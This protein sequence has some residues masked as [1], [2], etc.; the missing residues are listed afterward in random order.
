MESRIFQQSPD[1]QVSAPP[2]GHLPAG[3]KPSPGGR[4]RATGR[5]QEFLLILV[6]SVVL[7]LMAVLV[8]RPGG[9]LGVLGDFA[10]YRLM[11]S[12]TNQGYLPLVDYWMEYPPV[13][14]WLMLGL[15]RL[16][17]LIPA[18]TTPG[19]WFYLL[20]SLVLVA[21]NAGSLILFYGIARRLWGQR[22]AVYLSWI[23]ALLFI[24]LLSVFVGFDG[25]ALLF[26]LWAVL[27]TLDRRPIGS[28]ATAGLGFMI[29]LMPIAA[30][31]AA[32]QHMPRAGQ[33]LKHLLAA[34]LTALLVSLPF[35]ITAPQFLFQSLISPVKRSTWESVWALIDGYYSYGVAGGWDRFDPA[36]AGAAQHPTRLPWL[37]ITIG[38]GFFYLWLWTRRIDW[39]Q[40]RRVVAFTAL[41]QNLLTLYFKGYSPQFLVMLLPFVLLLVP[42]WRGVLYVL[43]LSAINLVEHPVYFLLLPDEHWL[44][45]GT[46]LLRTLILGVLSLEYAAQVF[47]WRIGRRWWRRTALGVLVVVVIAGLVGGVAGFRAYW[48]TRYETDPHHDAMQVLLD[49]ATAG[50]VAVVDDQEVYEHV[51]P[52][53]RAHLEVRAVEVRSYL[54]PWEPRLAEAADE[55]EGELWIYAAPDSPLHEWAAGRFQPLA[56]YEFDGRLLTRWDGP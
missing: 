13:F 43:L 53:L 25:L 2:A 56:R 7:Q 49:Q 14:P 9:Y 5:H 42:G 10:D 20:L 38:F 37:A 35:A 33:R 31:P 24:P 44:L 45:A 27:L 4:R 47:G 30:V 39:Q 26:L 40:P 48:A 29:K 34:G 36:M 21:A 17:L 46:V 22:R 55:A 51:Y 23:Y 3:G 12:F 8:F 11:L 19:T 52:Y 15:Y 28:G 41:T 16:S 1:P 32:L 18:W 54:P 6:L 50:S